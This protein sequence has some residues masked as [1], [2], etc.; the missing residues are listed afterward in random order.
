LCV[1]EWAC[2]S[3]GGG[4]G[5]GFVEDDKLVIS[6]MCHRVVAS[7][8]RRRVGSS[9]HYSSGAMPTV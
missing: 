6:G 3:P 8:W 1:R 5:G 2:F 7:T 9:C 4:G